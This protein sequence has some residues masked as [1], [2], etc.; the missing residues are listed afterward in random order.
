MPNAKLKL[1]REIQHHYI[2]YKALTYERIKVFF[3]AK[4]IPNKVKTHSH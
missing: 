1:K 3:Y 2:V 4:I